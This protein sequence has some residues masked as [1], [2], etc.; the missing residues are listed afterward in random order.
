[1]EPSGDLDCDGAFGS[2]TYNAVVAF[3]SANGLKPDGMVGHDTLDTISAKLHPPTFL[4]APT[5]RS[6]AVNVLKKKYRCPPG[7]LIC[8]EPPPD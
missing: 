2:D 5:T 4:H 1:V 8:A 6:S 3:Q 7:A